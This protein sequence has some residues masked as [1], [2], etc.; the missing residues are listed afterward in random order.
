MY[1]A[2]NKQV[3]LAPNFDADVFST[4]AG[5]GFD[6]FYAGGGAGIGVKPEPN[7]AWAFLPQSDS[8]LSTLLMAY[9]E[10]FAQC[11]LSP[12]RIDVGSKPHPASAQMML[13][14]MQQA[15]AVHKSI[16]EFA[17]RFD[18]TGR[19][20]AGEFRGLGASSA[21]FNAGF[22]TTGNN[23]FKNWDDFAREMTENAKAEA[24]VEDIARAYAGWAGAAMAGALYDGLV[25]GDWQGA[26]A[27]V[28][29]AMAK[30]AMNM[31]VSSAVEYAVTAVGVSISPLG[32][33]ALALA[34]E[35]LISECFEVAMKLDNHFGFGGDY[36]T[37]V[38][39]GD[40]KV[41]LY[42]DKKGLLQGLADMVG[43]GSKQGWLTDYDGNTAGWRSES[44]NV[45]AMDSATNEWV[46]ART[47][48]RYGGSMLRV[49]FE[50]F[51]ETG[52]NSWREFDTSGLSSGMPD[53]VESSAKA[54]GASMGLA[55]SALGALNG[56]GASALNGAALGSF[57][58]QAVLAAQAMGLGFGRESASAG[59]SDSGP[60]GGTRM[61]GKG[62][63]RDIT[64]EVSAEG[65]ISVNGM[66]VPKNATAATLRYTHGLRTIARQAPVDAMLNKA[67]K[68]VERI[69]AEKRAER[70]RRQSE[71][72]NA[73]WNGWGAYSEW[74]GST[75]TGWGAHTSE[76]R[77]HHGANLKD[78][79]HGD[80]GN[81]GFRDHTH[82]IG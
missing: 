79:S 39:I 27:N 73:D 33:S 29:E 58:G 16:Y 22:A 50:S 28:P 55:A 40:K 72:E 10:D 8:D 61:R 67:R 45:V 63:A 9:N 46:H 76:G 21:R 41:G 77:E 15:L 25:N 78:K 68:E 56:T 52:R 74:N 17:R 2:L 71:I 34:V 80:F 31:A 57:G 7:L 14:H 24:L 18:S 81:S 6:A 51:V 59:G 65:A 23:K 70:A 66:P 44:G 4:M 69:E 5:A 54:I 38:Q 64:V 75:S 20:R 35:G 19:D 53:V 11:V 30:M 26:G 82:N 37:S 62:Y 47:G 60:G 36:V 49:D 1:I 3:D 32:V 48:V 43:L 42:E 12:L 13:E